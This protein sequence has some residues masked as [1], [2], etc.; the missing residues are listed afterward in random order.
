MILSYPPSNEY[1]E[2]MPLSKKLSQRKHE[3]RSQLGNSPS[4]AVSGNTPTVQASSP[5]GSNTVPSAYNTVTKVGNERSLNMPTIHKVVEQLGQVKYAAWADEFEK[6]AAPRWKQLMRMGE[7]TPALERRLVKGKVLDY[8]K[9][10]SGLDRGSEALA[11]RHGIKIKE[12]DP[13][14]IG[15]EVT[16][17][18]ESL[19]KLKPGQAI[20]HAKNVAEE[21][22]GV[23]AQFTGGGFAL[24]LTNTAYLAPKANMIRHSIPATSGSTLAPEAVK[25]ITKRHE[26]RELIEAARQKA[27]GGRRYW[28]ITR[29]PQG[30]EEQ[31]LAKM[32][33]DNPVQ[34]VLR[35]GHSI[36]ERVLGGA[37]KASR[38]IHGGVS[39]RLQDLQT[40][41]RQSR[42][43]IVAPKGEVLLGKHLDPNVIMDESANI[44][45]MPVGARQAFKKLRTNPGAENSVLAPHNFQYGTAPSKKV[46]RNIMKA[47]NREQI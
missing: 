22:P 44:A 4:A 9:E 17:L 3:K 15:R 35:G 20:S 40:K 16:G 21:A 25:A 39:K 1:D 38:G 13:Q 26:V 8:A 29:K 5:M 33:S 37:S 32:I 14:A 11:K 46:R 23:L 42:K 12:V 31:A 28:T 45:T 18:K 27:R 2:G 24:P 7:I 43:A 6:V 10:I 34:R 36:A 47:F 30:A 19:R 41:V